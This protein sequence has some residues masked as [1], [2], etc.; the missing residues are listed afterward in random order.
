M[1][2]AVGRAA[3]RGGMAARFIDVPFNS[4]G[5]DAGV[6]LAPAAIGVGQ[7]TVPIVGVTPDRGEYGPRSEA[8]LIAMVGDVERVVRDAWDEG[9]VPI[10][11]GGDCPVMLGALRAMDGGGLLF[12][13]GHEDAWPPLEDQSGEAADSELGIALGLFDAPIPPL[14]RADRTLVLGPRDSAEIDDYG[15]RRV[16]DLVAFRDADWLASASDDELGATLGAV[17][18]AWWLHIDLDVLST[19]ALPAVDYPQPGG[20]DW[21]RLEHVTR[22][23]LR[24]PGCRGASVVI[25]NPELDDGASAGRIA[26]YLWAIGD[27]LSPRKPRNQSQAGKARISKSPPAT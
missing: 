22:R 26:E 18:D 20:I 12:I 27:V 6:A 10:L 5:T 14:L 7:L 3:Y 8:A 19:A 25:Y 11:V 21:E 24:R 1:P 23:I 15:I 16:S 2:D 4:G 9:D 13:D 17:G